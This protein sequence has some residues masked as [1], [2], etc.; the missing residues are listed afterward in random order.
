[1]CNFHFLISKRYVRNTCLIFRK[2][3]FKVYQKDGKLSIAPRKFAKNFIFFV[4]YV[5]LLIFPPGRRKYN[6]NSAFIVFIMR[7]FS[8]LYS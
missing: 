6:I 1:M 7:I 8:I 3:F 4:Q 2:K 5:H